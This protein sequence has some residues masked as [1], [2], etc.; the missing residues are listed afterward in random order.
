MSCQQEASR[1]FLTGAAEYIK[2]PIFK[3]VDSQ[4]VEYWLFGIADWV[5][6]KQVLRCNSV[7]YCA[8][9]E[10]ACCC[11]WR[12]EVVFLSVSQH[13]RNNSCGERSFRQ[14]IRSFFCD[15]KHKEHN[16]RRRPVAGRRG[17]RAELRA[18]LVPAPSRSTARSLIYRVVVQSW[19]CLFQRALTYWVMLHTRN[20]KIDS[21]EHYLLF[22]L[23]T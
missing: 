20:V 11:H 21:T 6:C 12:A 14:I 8:S 7:C 4:L 16:S 18:E 22:K 9:T 2:G 15:Q 23:K 10:S 5:D 1:T 13:H 3:K 17:W 19:R